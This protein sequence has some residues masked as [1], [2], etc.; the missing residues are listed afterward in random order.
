M[1][2]YEIDLP[3]ASTI[4]QKLVQKVLPDT[5][6]VNQAVLILVLISHLL[7]YIIAKAYCLQICVVH[8]MKH[9][10]Q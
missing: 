6:K 3:H 4:K 10:H 5:N 8:S 2:F 9:L 1:Q 7:P